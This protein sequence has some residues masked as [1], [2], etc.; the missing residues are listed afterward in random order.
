M[1]SGNNVMAK[2]RD[3]IVER[4]CF[5]TGNTG[6]TGLERKRAGRCVFQVL[7]CG[8]DHLAEGVGSRKVVL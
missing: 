4:K 8:Q 3:N 1:A 5:S 7:L 6:S 2:L